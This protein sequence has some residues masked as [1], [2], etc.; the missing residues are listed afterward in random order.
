MNYRPELDGL[1]ALAIGLVTLDHVLHGRFPGGFVGVDMFFVLSGYLITSILIEELA[2]STRI[3]LG[4]FYFRRA[5]RLMPALIV[6]LTLYTALMMTY[7]I[8]AHKMDFAKVH[9]WAA[10]AAGF[11]L[12][13]WDVALHIGSPGF[14]THTWS[15][16]IEEQF[17][18][19]WPPILILATRWMSRNHFII[20]CVMLLLI[21]SVWRDY[22]WL[23]GS[24]PMRTYAGFDTRFDNLLIGCLLALAPIR[25]SWRETMARHVWLPLAAMMSFAIW[26][27]WDS[28]YY[29]LGMTM[30]AVCSGWILIALLTE[31]NSR[32][33]KTMQLRAINYVGR[34]SY[35]YY[36]WHFPIWLCL[37][38]FLPDRHFARAV[39]TVTSA[40][41]VASI[42]YHWLELPA[43]RLILKSQKRPQPN[44]N[45]D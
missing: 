8:W 13:D 7:A 29:Q 23:D 24:S 27:K 32:L 31:P 11:Y 14:L 39:L 10:A 20:A 40:L 38:W 42:S 34:I 2:H 26:L 9:L 37:G 1:R 36:L 25:L 21:C 3:N 16:A 30:T 41:G 43:R 22:L 4:Q 6:M 19:L 28:N 5:L 12:M 33:A 45:K 44:L 35:G 18:L 17:Y 15:L